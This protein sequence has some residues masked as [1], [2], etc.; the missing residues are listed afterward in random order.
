[1]SATGTEHVFR[2]AHATHL[3]E[4][5]QRW[6]VRAEDLLAGTGLT[7]AA[8]ADPYGK[9][10]VPTLV[11]LLERARRLTQ[12]PALGLY[13][14][15]QT[16]PTLYGNVGFALCS[17]S[18]VREAIEITMRYGAIVTS[19]LTTRFRVD[20]TRAS[21]ILDEHADFGS[22]RDIVI[23]TSIIALRQVSRNL[24]GRELTT[25]V[26]D[27]ALPEPSYVDKLAAAGMPMRFNQPVHRLSFDARSLDLPY[28]MPDKAALLLAR[29]QCQRELDA[30]GLTGS[31]VE[32]VRALISRPEGGCRT[33]EEVAAVLHQSPRTVKRQLSA[34]GV[35]FSVLREQ[36]RRE[37][38][39]LLL[40]TPR[41]SLFEVA[42]RLGYSNVTNFERAFRRWTSGTPA[43]FRRAEEHRPN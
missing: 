43:Q 12:E 30:L 6:N 2:I 5:V 7:P 4:V 37:R 10:D 38:A 40:R 9:L 34:A 21:L 28:M 16:R 14:G 20:K 3:L 8:L 27:F 24:T 33:L 18:T 42:T 39:L 31:L 1:M 29:E 23:L 35:S 17:A 22:V 13:I 25:S 11:A 41:L 26:A 15:L 19:A 36:E 32:R